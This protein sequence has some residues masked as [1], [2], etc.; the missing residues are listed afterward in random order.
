MRL[1][2]AFLLLLQP[3][4][5]LL[6]A[7]FVTSTSAVVSWQ[8]PADVPIT[9]LRIYHHAGA[10]WPAGICYDDLP[11]G[12]TRVE[13]PG[14]LTHPAYRPQFGDRIVLAFG[15]DDVGHATLGESAVYEVYLGL[16][17]KQ[18]ALPTQRAVYLP[19]VMGR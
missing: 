6:Q 1:L 12:P 3:A 15:M 13:L 5:V 4:P 8:Q 18:S 19:V 16:I 7:V 11:A 14:A 17:T 9:C 10:A 2:L